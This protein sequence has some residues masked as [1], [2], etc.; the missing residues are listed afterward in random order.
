MPGEWRRPALLSMQLVEGGPRVAMPVLRNRPRPS[1]VTGMTWAQTLLTAPL[2]AR[3]P[4]RPHGA[5][6][7]AAWSDEAALDEFLETHPLAERL[8]GGWQ[9]R[10]QPLRAYGAWPSLP[11]L[12]EPEQPVADDEPVAVITL[13]RLR[14]SRVRPFLQASRP[15]EEQVVREPGVLL[16]SALARP[17]RIVST[18]SVWR[19]AREMRDYAV[20]RSGTAHLQ[21]TRAHQAEPFHHESVFA[22]FRPFA[23]R[24]RWQGLSPLADAD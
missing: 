21:A 2:P 7:L 9:V 20:G 3:F 14:L 16:T 8:A 19:T 5:A 1:E 12:G 13:G 24:G 6:L 18:F 4:P 23:A 22:R 11:G 10:L 15:A 17:P